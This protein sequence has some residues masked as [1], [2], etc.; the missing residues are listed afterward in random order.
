MFHVD[1]PILSIDLHPSRLWSLYWAP[2]ANHPG[3]K[4]MRCSISCPAAPE[5]WGKMLPWW[6]LVSKPHEYYTI[7]LYHTRLYYPRIVNTILYI[8]LYYPRVMNVMP[9]KYLNRTLSWGLGEIDFQRVI[10]PSNS[11]FGRTSHAICVLLW[12]KVVREIEW[13]MIANDSFHF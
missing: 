3:T 9:R 6:L 8:I 10:S 1:F 11:S 5:R 13:F 12:V 7:T 2:K 4:H